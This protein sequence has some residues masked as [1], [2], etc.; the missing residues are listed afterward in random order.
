MASAMGVNSAVWWDYV[1]V[2][3]SEIS[4]V[5]ESVVTRACEK[6]GQRDGLSVVAKVL[7]M[8]AWTADGWDFSLAGLMEN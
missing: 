5:D 8:V 4:P 6:V 3:K 7:T 2:G 1:S